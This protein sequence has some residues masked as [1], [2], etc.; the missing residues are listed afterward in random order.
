MGYDYWNGYDQLYTSYNHAFYFYQYLD[1]KQGIRF[2]YGKRGRDVLPFL[3][4]MR[5][6]LQGSPAWMINS[7][8]DDFCISRGEKAD[9][10][11]MSIGNAYW[12]LEQIIQSCIRHPTAKWEGD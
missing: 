6:A 3:L 10:W 2:I 9:G 5:S 11:K 8:D 4:N 7:C 1:K 12:F